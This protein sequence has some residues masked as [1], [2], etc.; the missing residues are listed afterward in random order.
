[1]N[2]ISY[3]PSYPLLDPRRP[4]NLSDEQLAG[5][6]ALDLG[7][8]SAPEAGYLG[9]DCRDFPGVLQFNLAAGDPWPFADGQMERLK[10]SHFIE[11]LPA[12]Q[13]VVSEHWKPGAAER[14]PGPTGY[15][16]L[17][18]LQDALCHFMDEAWRVTRLG[19]RFELR[20]PALVDR[21]EGYWCIG[22]FIDPTHRRFIPFET[23]PA[24]F[25]KAGR[26]ANRIQSYDIACNWLP[27]SHHQREC[28]PGLVEEIAVLERGPA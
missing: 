19:G 25:S 27:L 11:H 2:S 22:P 23:L 24:Y 21:K 10:S 6:V 15:V 4:L 28:A 13:V 8:G 26:D 18:K 5:V 9:V 3:D 17:C 12:T 14:S 16:K 20:W 1:V 7:S